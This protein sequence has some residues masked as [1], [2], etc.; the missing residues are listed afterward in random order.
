MHNKHESLKRK[1]KN[2]IV[3]IIGASENKRKEK[4]KKSWMIGAVRVD[5]NGK[6]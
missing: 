2:G 4:E 6:E 1:G 3:R 5:I